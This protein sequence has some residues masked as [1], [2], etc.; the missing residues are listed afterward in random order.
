MGRS[1]LP[2]I[3]LPFHLNS[4][5]AKISSCRLIP[6]KTFFLSII[7]LTAFLLLPG[8]YNFGW[9][10]SSEPFFAVGVKSISAFDKLS[11]KN[12]REIIVSQCI[13]T[14][15]SDLP[16]FD[17]AKIQPII[18]VKKAVSV[19]SLQIWMTYTVPPPEKIKIF[20]F[21]LITYSHKDSIHIDLSF[22]LVSHFKAQ[23]L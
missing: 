2:H 1:P 4:Q 6:L 21:F 11:R 9:G 7:F 22:T 5:N 20:E 3:S 19:F 14:T 16:K 23:S 17:I 18:E 13:K 12:E 15:G 10:K 8:I